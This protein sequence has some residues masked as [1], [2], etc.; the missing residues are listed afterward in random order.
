MGA[1]MGTVL[2]GSKNAPMGTVLSGSKNA[3]E[4]TVPIGAT[5]F[6]IKKDDLSRLFYTGD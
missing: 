5:E 3:P 2:S 1:P 4:R 6:A